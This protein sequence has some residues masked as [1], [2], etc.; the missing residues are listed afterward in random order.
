MSSIRRPQPIDGNCNFAKPRL[1]PIEWY[2]HMTALDTPIFR[3]QLPMQ[4]GASRDHCL[5]Y[6]AV[7]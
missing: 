2:L 6:L 7:L 1:L 3:A 5:L 4:C